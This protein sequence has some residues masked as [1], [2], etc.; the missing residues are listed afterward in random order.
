MNGEAMETK[1]IQL[2]LW[3]RRPEITMASIGRQ[4]GVSTQAVQQ[5]VARKIKSVRIAQGIADAIER[6]LA[7]VF[8]ELAE[9]SD[10]RRAVCN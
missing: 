7:D 3:K 4:I 1:E 5:T 6:P 2:E 10:R 9:C 8:P